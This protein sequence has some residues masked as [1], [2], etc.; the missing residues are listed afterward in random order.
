MMLVSL[1]DGFRPSDIHAMQ[2]ADNLI[3]RPTLVL[4]LYMLRCEIKITYLA[5]TTFLV[6]RIDVSMLP[7][8]PRQAVNKM[9]T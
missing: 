8:S 2:H 4:F 3:C 7:S 1:E 6:T 9:T 5:Y